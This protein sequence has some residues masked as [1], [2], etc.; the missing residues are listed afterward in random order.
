MGVRIGAALRRAER[1]VSVKEVAKHLQT[2]V[3]ATV[4]LRFSNFGAG[5][6][7]TG[8]ANNGP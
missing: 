1:A 4:G 5:A 2:I 6:Q 7:H 3:D 8:L